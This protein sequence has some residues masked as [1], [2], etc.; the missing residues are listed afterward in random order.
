M[1][2]REP[3]T[4]YART[5]RD[6][7][8]VWYWRTIDDHGRRTAGKSTGQTSKPAARHYVVDLLNRGR[9]D[10]PK[11]PSFKVYAGGWW[12]DDCSYVKGKRARGGF[13]SPGHVDNQRRILQKDLLPHFGTM[14]LSA[15]RPADIEAWVL[16][17]NETSSLAPRTINT[18]LTCLKTMLRAAVKLE[19]LDHSPA[20]YVERLHE[21]PKERGILYPRRGTPAIP[22]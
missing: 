3:F 6:G 22:G 11:D 14:R 7:R 19:L 18:R 4:L 13:M 5:M 12:T 21:T 1:G 15:I 9:L 20:E 17:L 10:A 16:S 2:F 8:K